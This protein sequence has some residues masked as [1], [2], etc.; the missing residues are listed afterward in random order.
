MTEPKPEYKATTATH[1]DIDL[2]VADLVTL[3][4]ADVDKLKRHA[5]AVVRLCDLA[6]SGRDDV[7]IP[8]REKR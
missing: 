1:T 7:T 8:R 6:Q 3:P 5:I 2:A 4:A